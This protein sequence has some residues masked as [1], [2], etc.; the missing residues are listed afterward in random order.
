LHATNLVLV[1]WCASISNM[2]SYRRG[3]PGAILGVALTFE[4]KEPAMYAKECALGG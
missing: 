3:S 2:S 1:L 4:C